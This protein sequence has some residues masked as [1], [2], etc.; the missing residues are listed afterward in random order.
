MSSRPT[1]ADAG[2]VAHGIPSAELARVEVVDQGGELEAA[3]EHLEERRELY[4]RAKRAPNSLK[5]YAVD[6]RAF[7][8]W[9]RPLGLPVLPSSPKVVASFLAHLADLGRRPSSIT[10]ALA[11][12]GHYHREAGFDWYAGH[13][14]IARTM[15][16]IRRTL[17][18]AV[19]RKAAI[20]G[21]QLE[22][23]CALLP[24]DGR[25]LQHRAILTTAWFGAL[26]RIEVTAIELEHVRFEVRGGREWLIVH[27]P[28]R[29]TD[30]EG[31]GTDVA[32]CEQPGSSACPVQ[33]LRAWLHVSGC[34]AGPIFRM[35]DGRSVALL[36]QRLCDRLGLDAS[37]F[38]AHSL[39]AGLAT[40]AAVKGWGLAAIMRQTGHV[41]E[42]T[43]MTYI[44]PG[45]LTIDNVTDG[46][47]DPNAG[48][49]RARGA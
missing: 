35:R 27:L 45:Q 14:E 4:A 43:A 23:M 26:R 32:I 40:T 1:S 37:T 3:L 39:R 16:G 18:K 36:V 34:K 30:Q 33:T 9:A 46:I 7:E 17:G 49:R 11:A 2:D 21:E 28:R 19:V 15:Q 13:L 12:I 22:A 8:A 20:T 24:P 31:E 6:W 25:G 5:R 41:S 48:P 42:K 10:V 47:L 38:G 44:R 29:K